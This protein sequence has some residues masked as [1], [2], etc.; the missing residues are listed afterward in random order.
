MHTIRFGPCLLFSFF[1]L[2]LSAGQ[3]TGTPTKIPKHLTV[4]P[5]EEPEDDLRDRTNTPG[6]YDLWY[7]LKHKST[8]TKYFEHDTP[9]ALSTVLQDMS[10]A[11][12]TQPLPAPGSFLTHS[13][14]RP[15][16]THIMPSEV[17]ESNLKPEGRKHGISSMASVGDINRN[18]GVP[19]G[20]VSFEV[21]SSLV[22]TSTE[23]LPSLTGMLIGKLRMN[24]LLV[25]S[26][27]LRNQDDQASATGKDQQVH[28]DHQTKKAL[29]PTPPTDQITNR[30][31]GP[32][33]RSVGN[34][35]AASFDASV[36]QNN[37]VF[38]IDLGYCSNHITADHGTLTVLKTHVSSKYGE[39]KTCT[40]KIMGSPGRF[41]SVSFDAFFSPK[42]LNV[43]VIIV[44]CPIAAQ[45]LYGNFNAI[46]PPPDVYSS[47]NCLKLIIVSR[48]PF[49]RV[50]LLT[51]TS[52]PSRLALNLTFLTETY[53]SVTTPFFDGIS[54]TYPPSLKTST[55]LSLPDQYSS[56]MVSFE[57]YALKEQTECI[58]FL[59]AT[60]SM[61]KGNELLRMCGADMANLPFF[62]TSLEIQY[63]SNYFRPTIGFKML[64][65]FHTP[66]NEPRISRTGRYNCTSPYYDLFKH[67]VE[68]NFQ[69]ECEN[70]E[71]EI[72]CWYS[73]ATCKGA[74]AYGKRCYSYVTRMK[75]V[76]W[77]EANQICLLQNSDLASLNTLQEINTILNIIAQSRKGRRLKMLIGLRTSDPN[78]PE[79]YKR[80]LQWNDGK[81]AL[82][83]KFDDLGLQRYPSCGMISDDEFFYE[84]MD[85][86]ERV[87]SQFLCEFY[88]IGSI[89]R[90]VQSTDSSSIVFSQ[91]N[92]DEMRLRL[93]AASRCPDGHMILDFLSCD[94]A[95]DCFAKTDV[96][97]C[98]TE[99][100]GVIPLFICEDGVQT[101][102]FTLVCNHQQDCRDGS[103][104]DRCV[105]EACE[106]FLC[107]N[108]QCVRVSEVCDGMDHCLTGRDEDRCSEVTSSSSS[109]VS[110]VVNTSVV[111]L[112]GHGL[113]DV[114]NSNQ[115]EEQVALLSFS[116]SII[117]AT[118]DGSVVISKYL[119]LCEDNLCLRCQAE[120]LD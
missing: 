9:V 90:K 3:V 109:K 61:S 83:F 6:R 76:T 14:Q 34:D 64:F 5:E 118:K 74:I 94:P 11:P 48:V 58:V 67:H 108:L 72:G 13:P 117:V 52:N 28:E 112:D 85:C 40:F 20:W 22:D 12:H 66:E 89:H 100:G 80:T 57:R 30:R 87:T 54:T 56:I 99:N 70:N 120:R 37:N 17:R 26:P 62:N 38:D 10:A 104:E 88:P 47:N 50:V 81:S 29:K 31:N 42:K 41:L 65:S 107:D 69:K 86:D 101:L 36:H 106:G 119:F 84:M 7:R 4:Q 110:R 55:L 75:S 105:F 115:S 98:E 25:S 18:G 71:D 97:T 1:Y 92:E 19:T 53:G 51:F 35:T 16:A 116:V 111:T 2:N 33:T 103:D 63:D 23:I 78:L 77:N 21:I 68:C 8:D 102:A 91:T 95:T 114:I 60:S 79:M 24:T 49:Q 43:D 96:D 46:E 73:S 82:D 45:S 32:T 59:K 27:P 93:P 39:W 113:Y 44:G 15:S